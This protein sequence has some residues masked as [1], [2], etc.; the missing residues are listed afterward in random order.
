MTGDGSQ[1]CRVCSTI[2]QSM[3]VELLHGSDR[4]PEATSSLVVVGGEGIYGA[5]QLRRCPSCG[6]YFSWIHDHDSEAGLGVGWTDEV[7]ARLDPRGARD[8]ATRAA[9]RARLSI[10]YWATAE[11][12]AT[13]RDWP[14]RLDDCREELTRLEEE[15]ANLTG[16]GGGGKGGSR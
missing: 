8:L 13:F 12:R 10:A 15:L 11:G 16:D 14:R 9:A 1:A 6:A 7:I 2:P 3:R 5:E 4:L